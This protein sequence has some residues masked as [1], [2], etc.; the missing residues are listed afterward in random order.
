MTRIMPRG[1]HGFIVKE[2]VG[3]VEVGQPDTTQDI[4]GFRLTLVSQQKLF[5]L[6]H[7]EDRTIVNGSH[8]TMSRTVRTIF[9]GQ[10][11]RSIVEER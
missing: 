10:S 3:V 7:K 6:L 8:N 9:T 2:L 5:K 11:T 1:L 4:S